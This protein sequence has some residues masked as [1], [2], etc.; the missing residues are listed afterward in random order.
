MSEKRGIRARRC[1]FLVV[2]TALTPFSLVAESDDK[3][4]MYQNIKP[5]ASMSFLKKIEGDDAFH[6]H[7]KRLRRHGETDEDVRAT[8]AVWKSFR[9]RESEEEIRRRLDSSESILA[10]PFTNE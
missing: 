10:T 4:S 8:K 3:Y 9:A 5:T 6:S 7:L 1:C 2:N